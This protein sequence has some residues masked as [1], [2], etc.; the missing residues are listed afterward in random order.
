MAEGGGLLN[1]YRVKSSIGGSNPPLSATK[2]KLL[3]FND[4]DG[5]NLPDFRAISAQIFHQRIS[6]RVVHLPLRRPSCSRSECV[7]LLI[8]PWSTPRGHYLW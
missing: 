3:D 4:L 1:R 8:R 2:S 6:L 7:E 5:A